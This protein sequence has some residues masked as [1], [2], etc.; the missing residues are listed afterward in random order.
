MVTLEPRTEHMVL[1]TDV[2]IVALRNLATKQTIRLADMDKSVMEAVITDMIAALNPQ[3]L[4]A[5]LATLEA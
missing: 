1:L 4:S 5:H 3:Q 2:Q